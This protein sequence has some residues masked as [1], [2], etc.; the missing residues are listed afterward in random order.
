MTKKSNGVPEDI[1]PNWLNVVRSA[2]AACKD[3][4]GYAI[5]TLRVAVKHNEAIMW[6]PPT[7]LKISPARMADLEIS[8]DVLGV[9]SMYMD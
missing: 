8:P 1:K 7:L 9:L 3:N 5:L 2:Q 4:G 6:A